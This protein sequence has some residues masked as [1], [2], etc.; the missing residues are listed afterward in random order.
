MLDQQSLEKSK[1]QPVGN[2]EADMI[3]PPE[4]IDAFIDLCEADGIPIRG[5]TWWCHVT[6]GHVP[7]GMGG[8]R[9]RYYDGWFSEIPMEDIIRLPDNGAYRDFFRNIW[10]KDKNCHDCWWPGFW[11]EA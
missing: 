9:S 6:E 1:I 2:G 10:P 4:H 7:C 5:F 8:P 3:C 11:L